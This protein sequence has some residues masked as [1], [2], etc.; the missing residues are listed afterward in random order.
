MMN[1]DEGRVSAL[2]DG[3]AALPEAT[4]TAR[5][6]DL[7]HE[8]AQAVFSRLA[9]ADQAA[10]LLDLPPDERCAWARR[11]PPDDAADCVQALPPPAR[12]LVLSCLDE[13]S[14]AEV[15]TLL[16]YAHDE[17]GGLMNPRFARMRPEMLVDDA[18]RDLRRQAIERA[19]TFFYVYVVDREE[20]LVGVV[21]VREL[22]GA[23][24]D[25][26]VSDVMRTDVVRV[27]ERADQEDV[28]RVLAAHDLA[29]VPV[30]GAGGR[31]VGV[32]SGDAVLDVVRDE[33][34]EDILRI[35]GVQPSTDPY[36]RTPLPL[37]VWRRGAWLAALFLGEMLTASAMSRYQDDIARSV[38]L[39]LF[40]PLI[41]SSGGN[42]GSQATSLVIR[43][44]AL[45]ELQPGHWRRVL[46]REV[47]AGGVLGV[48]LGSLG[49]AR[50]LAWEALFGSY[51][52]RAAAL[53]VVVGVSLLGIVIW[54]SVSGAMLPFA[55]RAMGLDPASASAPL[56]ATVVDVTGIVIYFT[57]ARAVLGGV[58][59]I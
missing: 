21:S 15:V 3:W 54:G 42:S 51:G 47:V 36:L 12:D 31:I 10:L 26:T 45:G 11:L 18:I 25:R 58:G 41:I 52:E 4:R 22:L 27:A 38:A 2:A 48:V 39:A 59:P 14:R 29:A 19:G 53:A 9:P 34:A 28:A 43:A 40:V 17:A 16:G 6:R 5:F 32:V 55:L 20:R 7:P 46:T 23:P 56:V 24:A 50:V 13:R 37:A 44:M 57:V 1:P 30:V 35:G 49:L 33:A 8:Q